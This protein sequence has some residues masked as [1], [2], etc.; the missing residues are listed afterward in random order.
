MLG[1][2]HTPRPFPFNSRALAKSR[3]HCVNTPNIKLGSARLLAKGPWRSCLSGYT[4]SEAVGRNS[5]RYGL[6]ESEWLSILFEGA[7][8]SP[9]PTLAG[10]EWAFKKCCGE[11]RTHF[12]Q[13]FIFK[14]TFYAPSKHNRFD[15]SYG[16]VAFHLSLFASDA[17][18]VEWRQILLI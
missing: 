3:W 8:H 17:Q 4:P 5:Q 10:V 1:N 6:D 12:N 7:Y 11:I 9:T 15:K 2:N 16:E 14:R 13:I 18:I